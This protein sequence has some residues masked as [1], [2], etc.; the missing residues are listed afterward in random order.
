MKQRNS[1]IILVIVAAILTILIPIKISNDVIKKDKEEI[2]TE[3]TIVEETTEEETTTIEETTTTEIEETTIQETETNIEETTQGSDEE[4]EPFTF[5]PEVE[6]TEEEEEVEVEIKE[7]IAA[8]VSMMHHVGD[9]IA[10]DHI[11][12]AVVYTD[13]TIA[14]NP[15][16]WSAYVQTSNGSL[17]NK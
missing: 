10:H 8:P 4:S 6:A 2:P 16:G 17:S 7:I 1:W 15:E 11:E 13:E 12:L 14:Y 9:E 5:Q 3:T